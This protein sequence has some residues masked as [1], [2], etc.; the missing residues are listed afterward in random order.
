MYLTPMWASNWKKFEKQNEEFNNSYL[1]SPFYCL[2]AK[3]D[4]GLENT[5]EFHRNVKEFACRYNME[6]VNLTGNVE[7]TEQAYLAARDNV[8]PGNKGRSN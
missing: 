7:I 1:K 4:T 6:I 5:P 2:V 8:R 3:I